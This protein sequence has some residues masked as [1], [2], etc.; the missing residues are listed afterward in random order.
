MKK[1][2]NQAKVMMKILTL[3]GGLAALAVL[4]VVALIGYGGLEYKKWQAKRAGK[5][6]VLQEIR[7]E[8][9]EEE[10]KNEKDSAVALKKIR[11]KNS[12]LKNRETSKE[13]PSKERARKAL[14]AINIGGKK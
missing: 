10:L 14:D 8:K 13:I 7:L 11:E 6:E 5:K 1:I 4:G 3:R 12:V 9:L 2:I